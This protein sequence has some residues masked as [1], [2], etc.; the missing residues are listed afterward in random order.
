[1]KIS[2]LGFSGSGKS[3]LARQLEQKLAAVRRPH[4]LLHLDQLHFA[5]AWQIRSKESKRADLEAFLKKEKDW[6][7]EGNY[8][9]LSQERLELSDVI[10]CLCFSRLCCWRS[11]W[12]RY[13]TYRGQRR[14]DMAEGCPERWDWDFDFWLLFRERKNKGR[15]FWKQLQHQ[16]PG[17]VYLLY[18]R[19]EIPSLLQKLEH[20]LYPEGEGR[21]SEGGIS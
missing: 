14:P 19:K 11:V 2:I 6:I 5:A 13:R 15:R 12:R 16:Y 21:W 9:S 18:S 3:S 8:L 4:A 7:I 10:I 17:R 20:K 1:M